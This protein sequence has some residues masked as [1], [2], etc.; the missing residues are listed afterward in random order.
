MTNDQNVSA[1]KKHNAHANILHAGWIFSCF[2]SLNR[3][4]HIH[5]QWASKQEMGSFL[6]KQGQAFKSH[7]DHLWYLLPIKSTN[8]RQGVHN[9]FTT[10]GCTMWSI[11][12]TA[13]NELLLLLHICLAFLLPNAL[14]HYTNFNARTP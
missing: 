8:N 11:W 2:P 1:N 10:A 9:L 7:S 4:W 14:I 12:I 5:L 13:T 3:S 6:S